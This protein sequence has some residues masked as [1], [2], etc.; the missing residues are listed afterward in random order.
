M[1][2]KSFLLILTIVILLLLTGC[3]GE[4]K[5]DIDCKKPH[6]TARCLNKQCQF[7]PI[8]NQIGNEICEKGENKCTAPAD[9]GICQGSN[10]LYLKYQ[11][12]NDNCVDSVPLDMIKP[13]YLS[14][15]AKVAGIEFKVT[16]DFNQPFNLKKDLFKLK[17]S[18]M[19][20]PSTIEDVTL[21]RIELTGITNDRRKIS[22]HDGIL[23]RPLLFE[24]DVEED[25]ILS[26]NTADISGDLIN[27]ELMVYFDYYVVSSGRR[28]LKQGSFPIRYSGLQKFT[29]V[30]P[31]AEYS[32][33]ESCDD[34]NKGTEDVCSKETGFFC[35]HNPIA[36]VCG[37]FLCESSENKCSC[38]E[39]CGSCAGAAGNY[40]TY[41]CVENDCLANLRQGF[42]QEKKSIFDDRSMAHFHLQ[43]NFEFNSPFNIKEDSVKLTLTLYD[44][45]VEVS[46][47]RF[48]DIRLF[49]GTDELAHT[50]A[51]IAMSSV[52]DSASASVSVPEISGVE[53]SKTLNLAVWYEYERGGQTTKN[54]FRKPLGKITLISPGS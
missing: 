16:S 41:A 14:S 48:T 37:N 38:E 4:C 49:E 5:K 35:Q 34:N 18:L 32:C 43:N 40:M 2:Y 19:N 44:K 53:D 42:T 28:T 27:L 8:P 36:N 1:K 30:L 3:G 45:S 52:G 13:V 21:K 9:C 10:G 6:F 51:N 20:L 26:L 31:E 54:D 25:L 15:D 33:P 22:L 39:D 50:F 11:C 7:T 23:N 47:I 12:I 46:Q 29:W 24:L 17:F